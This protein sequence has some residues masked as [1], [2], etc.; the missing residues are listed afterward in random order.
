MDTMDKSPMLTPAEAA[1]ALGF[2]NVRT[3]HNWVR[4]GKLKP[5]KLNA[6]V[7]RYRRD[8]VRRWV[9]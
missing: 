9:K 8:D 2:T 1:R 3:L 6:R 5:V 7:F 4:Q